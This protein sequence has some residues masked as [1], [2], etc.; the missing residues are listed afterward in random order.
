MWASW[1]ALIKSRHELDTVNKYKL[2]EHFRLAEML[3]KWS[4]QP[5]LRAAL[6]KVQYSCLL[7]GSLHITHRWN[8]CKLLLPVNYLICNCSGWL[9]WPGVA[10]WRRVVETWRRWRHRRLLHVTSVVASTLC[11]RRL[12]RNCRTLSSASP[13]QRP[14]ARCRLCRRSVAHRPSYHWQLISIRLEAKLS[15]GRILQLLFGAFRHF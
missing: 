7:T 6:F 4:V 10:I 15:F 12:D 1:P 13:P 11:R 5:Q 3:L 2:S 14:S 9:F 8:C